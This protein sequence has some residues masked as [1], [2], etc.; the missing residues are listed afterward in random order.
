MHL[1]L[2]TLSR[3]HL[4]KE[5]L[6]YALSN[7]HAM[8]FTEHSKPPAIRVKFVKAVNQHYSQTHQ[9]IVVAAIDSHQHGQ[10]LPE[11][12]FDNCNRS[13]WRSAL[14]GG[15]YSDLALVSRKLCRMKL[16]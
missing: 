7:R 5:G 3:L 1:T 14:R 13:S 15:F 2:M 10:P 9:Q 12:F 16:Y 6:C 11:R 4:H 8:L